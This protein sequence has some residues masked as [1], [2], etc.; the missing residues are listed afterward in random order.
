MSPLFD[1]TA[2]RLRNFSEYH[3]FSSDEF[4]KD[5]CIAKLL[6]IYIYT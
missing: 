6:A 4:E 5:E 3:N 2:F 1:Y